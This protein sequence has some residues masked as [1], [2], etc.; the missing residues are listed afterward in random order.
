MQRTPDQEILSQIGHG[1]REFEWSEWFGDVDGADYLTD[2]GRQA[3]RRAIA[4]LTRFF[5]PGWLSRAIEPGPAGAPVSILG[6]YAPLLALTPA[7]RPALFMES[8]RWWASIQTLVEAAV[9]GLAAV[10][11]DARGDLSTH[12]LVHTLTQTRLASIGMY[13]GAEVVLEPGKSGGPGDLLLRWAGQE[14][15]LE[16]VTFG[17]DEN[18]ETEENTTTG[19]S[20]TCSA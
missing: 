13:T 16:V 11:R 15:F 7:R 6:R 4:D 5:G 17:P 1:Q 8:I 19:I 9:V 18:T 2:V 20:C 14:V 10:R 12:R 3:A